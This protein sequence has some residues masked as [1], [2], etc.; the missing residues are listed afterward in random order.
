VKRFNAGEFINV[1]SQ[2]LGLDN[3]IKTIAHKIW[4][5]IERLNF[6]KSVHAITLA[7]CCVKFAC[8]LCSDDRQFESIAVAAGIT[9]MTLKN[10]YRD[11]YEYRAHFITQDCKVNNL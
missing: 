3:K 9:K 2:K 1:L 10:M 11:L 6:L 7:S 8:E 4:E 5:N